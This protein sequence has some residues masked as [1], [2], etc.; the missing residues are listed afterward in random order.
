MTPAP[1]KSAGS[2]IAATVVGAVLVL[3]VS[4]AILGGALAVMFGSDG[5]VTSGSRSLSTPRAALVTSAADFSDIADAYD[6]GGD[7]RIRISAKAA[8]TTEDLFIGIGPAAQVDR[9]LASVPIDEVT[10]VDVD[11]FRL[12][13]Q[14]HA[15]TKR[16]APPASQDFWVARSS[17]H[18]ADRL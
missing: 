17:G 6:V 16:P 8:G 7:P 10:D 14:S 1:P 5:T 4:L 15:G 12:T 18:D 11:T 9:Y 13:R 2:S 3:Y